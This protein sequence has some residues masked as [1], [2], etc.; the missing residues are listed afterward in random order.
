MLSSWLAFA[1]C[2]LFA[3]AAVDATTYVYDAN[4]RLV[5]VTN[6]AG[7][8][9]RYVYDVM[10]NMVRIERIAADELKIFAVT[11]T[12]GT[13]EAPVTIYGQGFSSQI[14]D[15]AVTFNGTLATIQSATANQLKV[16]VPFGATTGALTVR[17]AARSV[18][19]DDVFTVDDTGVPPTI[20]SVAPDTIVAGAALTISGT[21]LY[22]I[23]GKTSARMGGRSLNITRPTNASLGIDLPP[24]ASSGRVGVQTPYGFAESV[25]TVL[26]VPLVSIPRKLPRAVSRPW[27]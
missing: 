16:T 5:T 19:A 27:T 23:P 7:E 15:N 8:S 10:G 12:H 17:V 9:A 18:T 1:A 6:D 14:S 3:S 22:P 24:T 4:G 25:N 21:H 2:L 26:V 20:A 13:V 11:P